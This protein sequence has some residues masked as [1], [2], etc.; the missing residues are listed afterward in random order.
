MAWHVLL[1]MELQIGIAY[2]Q[3]NFGSDGITKIGI[4]LFGM[5]E[6]PF[7]S[8]RGG[9]SKKSA[10]TPTG[11]AVQDIQGGGKKI[12]VVALGGN[13]FFGA[14]SY[15]QCKLRTKPTT[16][17]RNSSGEWKPFRLSGL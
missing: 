2:R 16:Q 3:V 10:K 13:P 15:L 7:S 4:K 11:V 9:N 14:L 17:A 12:H 8:S 6:E 5:P 1:K